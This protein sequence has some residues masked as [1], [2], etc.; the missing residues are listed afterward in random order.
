[1]LFE[2]GRAETG[3]ERLELRDRLDIDQSFLNWTLDLRS[4]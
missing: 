4:K 1:V 2:L 3:V